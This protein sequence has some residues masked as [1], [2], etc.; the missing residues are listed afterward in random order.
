MSNHLEFMYLWKLN[1]GT[2]KRVR[3]KLISIN[4]T[5][6]SIRRSTLIR[7]FKLITI[8]HR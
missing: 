3:K 7:K 8:N 2:R 6:A 1:F 4:F 5:G